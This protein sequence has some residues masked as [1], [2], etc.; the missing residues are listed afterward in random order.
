MKEN[1]MDEEEMLDHIFETELKDAEIQA[2]MAAHIAAFSILITLLWANRFLDSKDLAY[3]A[4]VFKKRIV[5][6]YSKVLSARKDPVADMASKV[7][8]DIANGVIE[9]VQRCL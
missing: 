6:K 1:K 5:A 3:A 8:E 9:E 7:L 2:Q 4:D